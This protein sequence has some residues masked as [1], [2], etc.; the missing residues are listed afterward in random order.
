MLGGRQR[1]PPRA[2]RAYRLLARWAPPAPR[3][4]AD[5]GGE[6][7]GGGLQRGDLRGGA[8]RHRPQRHSV[9]GPLTARGARQR[10]RPAPLHG[11]AQPGPARLGSA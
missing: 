3:A 10:L 11:A 2:R 5:G 4:R 8:P 9:L 7:R 6:G 1:P